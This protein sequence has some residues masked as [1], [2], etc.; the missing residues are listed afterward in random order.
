MQV[1]TRV[2]APARTEPL[3]IA[4]CRIA[5]PS[6]PLMALNNSMP[7]VRSEHTD[8]RKT[9]ETARAAQKGGVL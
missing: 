2:A 5:L 7:W 4:N 8:I 9:F 3:N 1:V 6:R